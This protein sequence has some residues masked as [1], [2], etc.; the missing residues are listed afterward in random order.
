MCFIVWEF[1]FPIKIHWLISVLASVWSNIDTRFMSFWLRLL[2]KEES[3]LTHIVYMI[4][5]NL[6]VRDVY[7][8]KWI[9]R[10]KKIVDICGSSYLWLNHSMIY[11][12]LSKHFNTR[13]SKVLLCITGT[14]ISPPVRCVQCI[15]CLRNNKIL[16]IICCLVT[17]EN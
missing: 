4:A 15:D 14:Q 16:K 8:T 13:E 7:K 10:V 9:C 2:N 3:F 6:F 5:H 17:T 1:I 12:N 11:I